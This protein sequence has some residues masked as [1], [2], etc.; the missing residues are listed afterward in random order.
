MC[1][2]VLYMCVCFYF[3]GAV[4]EGPAPEL[5]HV[6]GARHVGCRLQTV[7]VAPEAGWF[8]AVFLRCLYSM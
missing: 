7:H 6:N 3:E 8:A 4:G 5:D 2:D 1:V